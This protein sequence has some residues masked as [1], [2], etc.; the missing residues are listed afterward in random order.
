MAAVNVTAT[1]LT[2]GS[3]RALATV[4]AATPAGKMD[5]IVITH[6]LGITPDYFLPQPTDA[7][8]NFPVLVYTSKTASQMTLTNMGGT[9][10][11]FVGVVEV[12][13]YHSMIR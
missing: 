9:A 11:S 12:G 2:G 5:T 6:N 7:S 10:T 13:S 8:T 4:A 3:L 1:L